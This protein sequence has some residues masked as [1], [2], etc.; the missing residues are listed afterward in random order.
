MKDVPATLEEELDQATL[1]PTTLRPYEHEANTVLEKLSVRL[2]RRPFCSCLSQCMQ[3]MTGMSAQ[4]LER[5][6]PRASTSRCDR[7]R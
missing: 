2:R 3:S 5:D 7:P 6:Q 1:H 4:I